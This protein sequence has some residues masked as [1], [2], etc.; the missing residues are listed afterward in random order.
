MV[1][2][3]LLMTGLCLHDIIASAM[4]IITEQYI[5]IRKWHAK[6]TRLSLTV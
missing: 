6:L 1:V 5:E 2:P 4:A 3:R